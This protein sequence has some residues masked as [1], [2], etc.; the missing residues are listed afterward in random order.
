[1]Q[2]FPAPSST[3]RRPKSSSLPHTR[4][5]ATGSDQAIASASA[6]TP[7]AGPVPI[8]AISASTPRRRH[9]PANPD[10]EVHLVFY[11]GGE[12]LRNLDEHDK[13]VK[14]PRGYSCEELGGVG[15]YLGPN[16]G[17]IIRLS[18]NFPF[19]VSPSGSGAS[20][21]V[22]VLAANNG[23]FTTWQRSQPDWSQPLVMNFLSAADAR[24]ILA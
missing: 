15:Y 5:A 13:A 6:T 9:L 8:P 21:Y 16:P 18:E 20:R 7:S 10:T 22:S 1:M 19:F 2:P 11:D 12:S 23:F 4:P 3:S 17:S 24:A 14:R